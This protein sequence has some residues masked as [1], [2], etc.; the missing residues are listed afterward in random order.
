L[1][2]NKLLF[3]GA[4]EHTVIR[5]L[6]KAKIR[7]SK[8]SFKSLRAHNT[9]KL[10]TKAKIKHII[11]FYTVPPQ[12]FPRTALKADYQAGPCFYITYIP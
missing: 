6:T 8:M 5:I 1:L 12:A 10:L 9:V 3:P 11:N 7:P 2:S 4:K